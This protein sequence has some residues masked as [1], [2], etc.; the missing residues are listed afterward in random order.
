MSN[1]N[2][3]NPRKRHPSNCQ[4]TPCQWKK[5]TE[6]WAAG[7]RVRPEVGSKA[8]VTAEGQEILEVDAPKGN[9]SPRERV[10]Q[11]ISLRTEF[12][13]DSITEIA[14]RMGISRT[15]LNQVIY[16]ATKEGWLRYS[17]PVERFE[18]E[19]VPKVVDN[20]GHFIDLKDKQMTI[21]AAKGAGI[22]KSHQAVKV[23]NDTPQAVLAL[24][25]ETA[26]GGDIKIAAGTIV[27][28]AR[29]EVYE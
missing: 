26:P 27:G 29:E 9:V 13:T 18:M 14:Q 28:K 15:W 17:N 6:S 25:I 22:F 19:I 5:E 21:E 2:P 7:K 8:L 20:I 12:P 10:L 4:C 3:K 23:E 24:K 1:P 11:Y 16:K